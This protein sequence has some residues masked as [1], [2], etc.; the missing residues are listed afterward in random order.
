MATG[1]S[2]ANVVKKLE[3]TSLGK[4]F[5]EISFAGRG[6]KLDKAEDA[7]EIVQ[8]IN[9][10]DKVH[11]LRLDGNTIGADAAKS[12]AQAL[13]KHPEFQTAL[14]SDIFTGR[15]R[16]EIPPSLMSLGDALIESGA[17]LQELD[18]SDNAFGPDGVKAIK[19]LLMSP[20]CYSLEVLKLNNNGLGI[21][22]GKILSDAL[23]SCYKESLSAGTPLKLKV[24]ISG[25]NRLE[26][27]GAIAMSKVFE[28]LK[29]L[30]AVEMP[31][32]GI[33]H[34][35]I[36]AL[37]T[38][39]AL[40]PSLQVVNLND[41]TFGIKGAMSLAQVLESMNSLKTLNLGDA[42][43]RNNGALAIS[44]ALKRGAASLEEIILYGNE[45][46]IDGALAVVEAVSHRNNL[47]SLNLDGNQLGDA[48]D[49]VIEK[50]EF[51]GKKDKLASF[52]DNEEPDSGDEDE[53]DE[54]EEEDE[55]EE[56]EKEEDDEGADSLALEI[57][58]I[59][60][61]PT[62][63]QLRDDSKVML[64]EED[65]IRIKESPLHAIRAVH[66]IPKKQREQF[67]KESFNSYSKDGFDIGKAFIEASTHL[68]DD[69]DTLF[70]ASDVIL[71]DSLRED[72]AKQ[73]AVVN[74]IL[75]HMGLLKSEKTIE[76]S[77]DISGPL[78]ALQHVA[79]QD[80]FPRT[81]ANYFIAFLSRPDAILDVHSKQRH[82]LFQT[83]YQI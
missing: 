34:P 17:K 27:D 4:N 54:D 22:G 24:F 23:L 48:V 41:N 63:K 7:E 76:I 11:A 68:K 43:I 72:E 5:V 40:N 65:T 49:D 36:T 52:D 14:W 16:S 56:E 59:G 69:T 28:A 53:G 77:N 46:R 8:A 29:S 35:G 19:K 42:L 21:G 66:K 60:L 74:S 82:D 10:A 33:H 47:K 32:N 30:E 57:K 79:R 51:Y 6:L 18:L 55:E 50:M 31:Q 70:L 44:T 26:N 12:I 62:S 83:L 73:K 9:G 71:S 1:D 39:F 15:V 3:E 75:V 38:A 2:T 37:V 20:V 25:R 61:S 67:L 13:K 45:I 64:D 80:Y 81:L 58:G 78:T